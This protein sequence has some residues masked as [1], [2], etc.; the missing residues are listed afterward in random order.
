MSDL[1]ADS[2]VSS[3]LLFLHFDV[4]DH[5][6]KLETY[7][8]TA[9]SA[10]HVLTTMNSQFFENKLDFELIVLPPTSGSFLTRLKIV[11]KHG[12]ISI[13]ALGAILESD[14]GQSIVRGLTGKSPA[15]W[16][17]ETAKTSK[18]IL[19]DIREHASEGT[20]TI[21]QDTEQLSGEK[22]TA[23]ILV[24]MT[25]GILEKDNVDLINL[26]LEI[27][28]AAEILDAR[29]SFYEAC[30]QDNDISGVGFGEEN[31]FPVPRHSF[32]E[33]ARRPVRNEKDE[34]K[35]PWVVTIE[36]IFAT[37]PN[38]DQDDQ[39]SRK[40][41]GRNTAGRD[42][43]F[44]V[45]DDHFWELAKNK[46]LEVQRYDKIRVQWAYKDEI[47]RPRDRKVLRVL[48]FNDKK[49]AEPLLQ[50]ALDATISQNTAAVESDDAPTL[51]T[52][53]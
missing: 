30:I 24:L 12:A 10:K 41:K 42:C 32:P 31:D 22:C 21:E 27:G 11:F 33:R 25:R 7:I 20:N 36:T 39:L 4:N 40:W 18:D 38:W 45:V 34:D 26:G 28:D 5:Y 3:E 43:Y 8:A 14:I 46:E 23:K 47:G 2:E 51:F 50:E 9:T 49:L 29:A 17:E 53:R 15:E 35:S 13:F 52:I 16:A 6:L 44:I 1:S 48:E 37:S 19:N